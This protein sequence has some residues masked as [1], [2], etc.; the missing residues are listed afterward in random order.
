MTHDT[1]STT[2][3]VFT[4]QWYISVAYSAF[5]HK[6]I[7]SFI[8]H[9]LF[10]IISDVL[11]NVVTKRKHVLDNTQHILVGIYGYNGS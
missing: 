5:T 8:S 2:A 9:L 4:L 11:N 7:L 3:H 10:D 6:D 1:V